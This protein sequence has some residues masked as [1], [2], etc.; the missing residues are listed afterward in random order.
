MKAQPF[1]AWG[2]YDKDTPGRF[3]RLEH[4]CADVAACFEV[5]VSEPVMAARFA[6][7]A[8][9]PE[10]LDQVTL[11]RLAVLAFLH[12]F[13]KLNSGFQFKVR[14]RSDL[15]SR[16]PI[17]A[18]H[19]SEAFFA[20]ENQQ[21]CESIGF[22]EI[23]DSWG[24][25]VE[26]LL[27]AALAH[28]GRPARRRNGGGG[29]SELWEPFAGYDPIATAVVLRNCMRDWFPHAFVPDPLP[30]FRPALEHLFA[31]TVALADQIGSDEKN[32]FPFISDPDPKYIDKARKQ[33]RLAIQ[34]RGLERTSWRKGASRPDFQA[35]FGHPEPHPIQQEVAKASVD[36]PLLILESETGSGKTEAA[37]LRFASLWR[38]GMVDGLYFAVP[39]RAAAKQLQHRIHLAMEK[40][41]P[42]KWGKNT[43]LAV[44]GYHVAG[45]SEGRT[46]GKYDVF[47]E[48][49]PDEADRIARW[50]AESTRHF[51]SSPVAV[52]T[53]DQAL[54]AG[55]Q[56]KWAHLRGAS[57]ARSLLVVDEVHASDAYMNELLDT[58]LKSHLD[59]GG[60]AMLMSATLGVSARGMFTADSGADEADITEA[61]E[62]AY[63]ALTLAGNGVPQTFAV[64]NVGRE[65]KVSIESM[66]SIAEPH[67]IADR[68]QTAALRGA[69]VLVIRNTVAEAQ[70]IFEHLKRSDAKDLLLSV[71]GV[72]TLHHS[73]F[74]AE[75]RKR[76]DDAVESVL[77]KHSGPNGRIVIGTQTLEQSLD[78][79]ADILI[80]DICPVD[81]LLQRIG[82]LH[83]HARER[84]ETFEIPRCIVLVPESGLE[85][86][87]EGGL[88][89]HGLGAG[90]RGGGIY[91]DLLGIEQT[92][93]LIEK[94]AI[95]NIPTMNRMLVETATHPV[96]LRN[97]AEELGGPWEV[98]E[99]QTFGLAAA[100][101]KRA[102]E[103]SLDRTVPFNEDLNFV[104]MDEKVRTR[105]GEDGP[106]IVLSDKSEGPFGKSVRTFNLPAHLFGG[107]QSTPS[108]EEIEQA[109]LAGPAPT[110]V[111]Q[112]GSHR[113]TYDCSGIRKGKENQ[114]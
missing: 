73:R 17:N 29:P 96:A 113:F 24:E 34:S 51:L 52:G 57:L 23:F 38:A 27:L 76:L 75:D 46:V 43:V 61:I 40:L 108:R 58:L 93:R 41:I 39:T 86:G 16:P 74:A 47:W 104:D 59:L 107:A 22:Y 1:V 15:P 90:A 67:L 111:L 110:A 65:K 19:I 53:I 114:F 12:D 37:V 3:H 109:K 88:M 56:T 72:A 99:Q 105:L 84:P 71:N 35:M 5:L 92:R 54:L 25:G 44:P 10:K 69:K 4:H 7:A 9:K 106:R 49:K 36:A 83:R 78:I 42:G 6:R 32:H 8:G 48:D 62:T 66:P 60:H 102:R 91:R 85:Q 100:E 11:S 82:R 98:H 26:T 18:G 80:T 112:V 13:A 77:G 70:A 21:L 45:K 30:S 95:W 103:H 55:T 101:T 28:H 33:A 94:Y 2:K 79:D 89:R 64:K 87:L 31:G 50:S 68:A 63:P 20:F 81:V 97:L 14:D